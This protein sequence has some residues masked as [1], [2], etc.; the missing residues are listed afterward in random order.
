MYYTFLAVASFSDWWL[1]LQSRLYDAI[2]YDD[3]WKMYLEGLSRTL[4][5][6]VVGC[7]LGVVLGIAIAMVK[8]A[9]Q[10]SKNPVLRFLSFLC[11]VYTTVIRGTP[12][13]IQLLILYTMAIM[14]NGLIACFIGFGINSGAYLSETFRSG[15]QSVDI[16][17]MEA[18][19]SLGLSRGAAMVNV[20]LPQAIKNMLPAIF[21][22]FIVLVK[23][24]SIAGY[25]AVNDLTKLSNA[26][27]NRTYD[28]IT[29]YIT[30]VV[31]LLLTFVLT[32][33]LRKLERRF[34]KSDRN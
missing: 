4:Q 24:T 27:R 18:A 1:K 26:I 5:M 16:G 13:M 2:I 8:T 28:S 21:N 14:P 32:L 33:V 25:I 30:A 23:E 31:Y 10:G 11:S 17:Q 6:A 22:E 19:R 20:V 34:A 15:I 7:I 9:A 29:Y 3:R 12:L